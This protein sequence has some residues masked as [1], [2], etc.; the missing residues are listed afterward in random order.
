MNKAKRMAALKHQ[1]RQKKLK[2]KR[3]IQASIKK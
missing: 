2:E 3:K 1:R